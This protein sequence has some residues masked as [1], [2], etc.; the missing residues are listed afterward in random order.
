M[1][2]LSLSL[3]LSL[4]RAR[5]R[6]LT[7]THIATGLHFSQ[8]SSSTSAVRLGVCTVNVFSVAVNCAGSSRQRCGPHAM[9][10]GAFWLYANST[11][12]SDIFK[13]QHQRP[14]GS[15][16]GGVRS[17]VTGRQRLLVAMREV[18]DETSPTMDE[19]R[20]IL[21]EKCPTLDQTGPTMDET[22]AIQ[23]HKMRGKN[24]GNGYAN[25]S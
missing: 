8:C 17:G 16:S 4:S 11:S 15:G 14:A 19:T 13:D 25:P 10:H 6:S 18:M 7:H 24:T 20:P 12:F 21:D 9:S 5:A 3:S 23:A 2:A 1:C 22:S